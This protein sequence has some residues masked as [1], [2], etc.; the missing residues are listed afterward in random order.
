MESDPETSIPPSVYWLRLR[1]SS[2]PPRSNGFLA[3]EATEG[4]NPAYDPLIEGSQQ[5]DVFPRI[6]GGGF[7]GFPIV[8]E[9]IRQGE[10]GGLAAIYI[11]NGLTERTDDSFRRN[12]AKSARSSAASSPAL[13]PSR[14]IFPAAS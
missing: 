3:L 9:F 1:A 8:Q 10:A 4:F 5:L 13:A 2:R 6:I 14:S 12:Q 7:L 11:T